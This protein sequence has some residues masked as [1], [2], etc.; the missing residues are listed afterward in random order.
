MDALFVAGRV[1]L[2]FVLFVCLSIA[3]V[4]LASKCPR[5]TIHESWH[6]MINRLLG[7]DRGDVMIFD[8]RVAI[9]FMQK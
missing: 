2:V 1:A 3:F 5:A 8:L 4:D 6:V 7:I 9:L